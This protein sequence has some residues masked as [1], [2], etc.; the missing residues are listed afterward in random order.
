MEQD[1]RKISVMRAKE[2]SDKD[3]KELKFK[4]YK[5]LGDSIFIDNMRNKK[6]NSDQWDLLLLIIKRPINFRKWTERSNNLKFQV[7]L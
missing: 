1:N 6:N 5:P 7:M 4:Y 2:F 3:E